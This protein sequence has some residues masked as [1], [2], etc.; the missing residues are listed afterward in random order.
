MWVYRDS[1]R[2]KGASVLSGYLAAAAAIGK[3]EPKLKTAATPHHPPPI[4]HFTCVVLPSQ[5][6][7]S[8]AREGSVKRQRRE[9]MRKKGGGQEV[10]DI[11]VHDEKKERRKKRGGGR[12]GRQSGDP[13]GVGCIGRV[14]IDQ[15]NITVERDNRTQR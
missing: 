10:K 9:S 14:Q 5:H 7:A 15:S 2:P 13:S 3:R 6:V 4:F 8:N 11:C 12:T 1:P